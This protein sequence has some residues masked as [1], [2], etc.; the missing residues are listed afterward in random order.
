MS[1]II[2]FNLDD[3]DEVQREED[4]LIDEYSFPKFGDK[5]FVETCT[6][7]PLD[8]LGMSQ[9][10]QPETRPITGRREIYSHGYLLVL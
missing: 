5:L 2:E 8:P 9:P 1:D 10:L 4:R 3:R 6:S 7:V